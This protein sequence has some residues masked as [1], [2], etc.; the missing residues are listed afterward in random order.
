MSFELPCLGILIT[1]TTRSE[2]T[3]GW[4][5]RSPANTSNARRGRINGGVYFLGGASSLRYKPAA[6]A[7]VMRNEHQVLASISRKK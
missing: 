2:G 7:G 3:L 1:T 6:N 5:I 4:D